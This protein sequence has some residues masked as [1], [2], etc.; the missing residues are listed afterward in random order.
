MINNRKIGLALGGGGIRGLGH[1]LFLDVFDKYGIRPDVISGSSIGAVAGALYASGMSAADIKNAVEKQFG[2][3]F[4]GE[5]NHFRIQDHN[6]IFSII[7][8][9]DVDFKGTGFIKGE[10]F[11]EFLYGLI[12]KEN[13]E[14]L[15][16]PLRVTATDYW[17]SSPYNI[18]SGPIVPAV[19]ASMS[20]PGVFSP[21]V[22]KNHV[23]VD[24]STLNPVPWDLLDDCNIR[25]G[26]NVLGHAYSADNEKKPKAARAVFELFDI[27]QRGILQE[28]LKADPPDLLISPDI[29]GVGI[30]DINKSSQVITNSIAATDELETFLKK[31]IKN[32]K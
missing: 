1:L 32:Q 12:K 7:K 23:L 5:K 9:L 8:F 18:D 11:T 6:S 14:E 19:K 29:N 26:I 31:I 28:K 2:I 3:S 15:E 17:K 22:Y 30:L 16:I 21:V 24:G 4:S 27:M 25:I 10:K 13:F 20:V